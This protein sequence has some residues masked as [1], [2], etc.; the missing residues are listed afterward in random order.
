[1]FDLGTLYKAFS[2]YFYPKLLKGQEYDP[3][4][5][6]KVKDALGFLQA[7]LGDQ[8]YLTGKEA[9]VADLAIG[10]SLYRLKKSVYTAEANLLKH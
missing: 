5:E 4:K 6:Q 2:E 1:M 10:T 8:D 3:E 7:F 9:T